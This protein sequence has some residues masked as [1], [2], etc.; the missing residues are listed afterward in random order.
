M[1]TITITLRNTVDAR[2][3][4]ERLI[5]TMFRSAE[6]VVV[7]GSRDREAL[8]S[9][10]QLPQHQIV[11]IPNAVPDPLPD[12]AAERSPVGPCHLLFLGH[13]ST[14]KGVPELVQ[15]LAQPALLSRRWRATLA[16][17]GPVDEYRRLAADLDIAERVEFPGWVDEAQ[18]RELCTNADVLVLPS[19]AEGLAMAVLE[20]LSHGL[21]VVTTPVGAHPEVIEQG[22]SGILVPPGDVEALAGALMRVIDDGSLRR[23]LGAGARRRFLEK[24]DIRGYAERLDQLHASLLR[25]SRCPS[26]RNRAELAMTISEIDGRPARTRSSDL[27]RRVNI[28]G[29]GVM[30][31]NLPQAVATLDR[32]REEGRRDYVCCVSVHGIVTAQ[33]D[34][35]IR[36]ALNRCGLAT[37]D[38]MPLVWWCRRAGFSQAGRVC[39]SDLLDAM[40]ALAVRRGHR[41]YFYGGSPHVVEQLV[42]CLTRRY[43][44]LVIAGLSIAPVPPADRRGGRGRCRR[45]QCGASGFRM[46][47]ARPAK[48]GKMDGRACRPHR[49]DSVDWRRRRVRFPRRDKAAGP[50]MDAALRARMAVPADQRTA[51]PRGTLFDRQHDFPRACRA[52]A[53]RAQILPARIGEALPSGYLE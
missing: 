3:W 4:H 15:A 22:V 19:H 12:T 5:A 49:G 27:P 1:S 30:P 46:G 44:G 10:L 33:R 26:R 28:L 37:E 25:T 24:F 36:N 2:R 32:W 18:V 14:R 13:L 29:V 16:G 48:A 34:P 21:A 6:K 45:D 47:R 40:C 52:A 42:S 41:H 51:P 53:D 20:G 43:P 50:A 39:G 38:G 11:V 17:G 23:Q 8:V 7:L 35:E 9:L 31:L